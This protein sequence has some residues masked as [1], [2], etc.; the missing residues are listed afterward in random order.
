MNSF[1]FEDGTRIAQI[2]P[3]ELLSLLS[4][5]CTFLVP[6][7]YR[8]QAPSRPVLYILTR[9]TKPSFLSQ[10]ELFP[11]HPL[12]AP[13][14][15]ANLFRLRETLFLLP[16]IPWIGIKLIAFNCSIP[17]NYNAE[18]HIRYFFRSSMLAELYTKFSYNRDELVGK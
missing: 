13:A 4:L 10:V 3:A 2:A 7:S 11:Y 6:E 9:P 17:M 8:G 1:G 15:P 16:N 12:N 18:S 5:A 14:D